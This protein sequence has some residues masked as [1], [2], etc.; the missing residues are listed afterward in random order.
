LLLQLLLKSH[1]HLL[2]RDG[3][4]GYL[5]A[6]DLQDLIQV[7]QEQHVSSLE[8]I[9]KV[10]QAFVVARADVTALEN[11]APAEESADDF[12]WLVDILRHQPFTPNYASTTSPYTLPISSLIAEQSEHEQTEILILILK[13]A[14]NHHSKSN[15]LR[16]RLSPYLTCPNNCRPI[17]G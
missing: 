8:G 14:P 4:T 3:V 15:I 7:L 9:K 5:L 1:S 10:F 11:S 2:F 13:V 12:P 16:N 17:R 6:Q